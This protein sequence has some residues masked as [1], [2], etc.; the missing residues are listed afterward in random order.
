MT[1]DVFLDAWNQLRSV[2]LMADG[3]TI[4]RGRKSFGTRTA[5]IDIQENDTSKYPKFFPFFL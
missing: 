5:L 1:G 3:H 2:H 4:I